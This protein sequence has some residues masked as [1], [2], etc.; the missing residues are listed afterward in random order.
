VASRVAGLPAGSFLDWVSLNQPHHPAPIHSVKCEHDVVPVEHRS[1]TFNGSHGVAP[2]RLN[3][4]PEDTPSVLKGSQNRLLVG[5]IHDVRNSL[6]R[7]D[8]RLGRSFRSSLALRFYVSETIAISRAFCPQPASD[9][10]RP[11]R[12]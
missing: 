4:F 2:S 8:S 3:V 5:T 11:P 9:S 1:Q 7:T 10:L 6:N 12:G